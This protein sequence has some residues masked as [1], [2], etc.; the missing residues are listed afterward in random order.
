[1]LEQL[2][3]ESWAAERD[4]LVNSSILTHFSGEVHPRA[5][6]NLGITVTRIHSDAIHCEY[7]CAV[8]V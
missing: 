3:V 1:M 7:N 5:W 6:S 8:S 4:S 2:L